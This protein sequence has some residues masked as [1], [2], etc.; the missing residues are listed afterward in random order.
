MLVTES[1]CFCHRVY[2]FNQPKRSYA[3]QF[4]VVGVID[5]FFGDKYYQP[6]NCALSKCFLLQVAV[7]FEFGKIF[8]F[9]LGDRGWGKSYYFQNATSAITSC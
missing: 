2:G 1:L 4:I 8:L 9:L 5:I 7:L 6:A 3:Y